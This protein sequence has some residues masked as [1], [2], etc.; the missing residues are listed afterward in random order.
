MK[1]GDKVYFKESHRARYSNL[2]YDFKVGFP[3]IVNYT[4]PTAYSIFDEDS[5][6]HYISGDT[7]D[8]IISES[9]FI[10]LNREKM[11]EK[12]LA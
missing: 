1:V 9:E 11:L 2:I 7:R 4:W 6:S 3:Y 12:I 10:K 8:K 5:T